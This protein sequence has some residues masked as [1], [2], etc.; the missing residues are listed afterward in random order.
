LSINLA[1]N[2]RLVVE[3]LSAGCSSFAS[4]VDVDIIERSCHFDVIHAPTVVP[5]NV[6]GY[7][8]DTSADSGDVFRGGDNN[9]YFSNFCNHFNDDRNFD[10]W[11]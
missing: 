10:N 2:P 6:I 1:H 7:V 4:A 8:D 9:N 5:A 11:E 3:F